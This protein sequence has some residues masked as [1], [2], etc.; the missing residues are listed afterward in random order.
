MRQIEEK[1]RSWA[2]EHIQILS[3]AAAVVLTILLRY[4][5]TGIHLPADYGNITAHMGVLQTFPLPIYI[6]IALVSY[7]FEGCS[8]VAVYKIAL[9]SCRV[10]SKGAAV[11]ALLYLWL[12]ATVLTG[13]MLLH[14]DAVYVCAGLWMIYHMCSR[15]YKKALL[16]GAAGLAVQLFIPIVSP[17]RYTEAAVEV[18]YS[19]APNIYAVMNARIDA[20]APVAYMVLPVIGLVCFLLYYW[21]RGSLHFHKGQT[22][23]IWMWIFFTFFFFAPHMTERGLFLPAA[24]VTIYYLLYERGKYIVPVVMN[25]VVL[26]CY[27]NRLFGG[28]GIS[29][30]WLAVIITGIYGYITFGSKTSLNAML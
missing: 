18:L 8:A 20:Y 11:I 10:Q 22:L 17:L 5:L 29:T 28:I 7:L 15:Q 12:P 14:W 13:N 26:M 25:I 24:L 27:D 2:M 30:F 6:T 9:W 19:N 21:R 1:F 16:C 4:V 23:K 3:F